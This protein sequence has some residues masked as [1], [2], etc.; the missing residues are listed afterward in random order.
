M[1][2]R[3]GKRVYCARGLLQ[4]A[5]LVPANLFGMDV[6]SQ[7]TGEL[8]P[9]RIVTPGIYVKRLVHAPDATKHI[10]QRTVRKRA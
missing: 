5:L 3:F 6:E 7:R 4:I 1:R 9:D 10:E 2:V 8:D